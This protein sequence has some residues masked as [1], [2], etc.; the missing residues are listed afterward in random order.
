[1]FPSTFG[2]DTLRVF[3]RL[4]KNS[5][6]YFNEFSIQ[7]TNH[8]RHNRRRPKDV[9]ALFNIK[10][11][12]GEFLSKFVDHFRRALAE[13]RDVSK[14]LVVHAFKEA[15]LFDDKG[16]YNSIVLNTPTI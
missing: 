2:A 6:R 13:I 3:S 15:L 10:Q 11:N 1:M 12:E 8:F 14:I 16:I 5:I 4:Q 9:V 7:F